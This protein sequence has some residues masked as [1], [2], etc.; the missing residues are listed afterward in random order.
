MKAFTDIFLRRPVLA[1]VVNLIIL[2]AGLQAIRSLNVRQYP[3]NENAS[4]TITTAYIGASAELVRGFITTP[5]ERAIAAADGIDYIESKSTMG[6]STITVRLKLNYDANKALAQISSKIDQVRND[7]PPEAEV[8]IIN[9][10]SADSQFAA[11][12][13]SFTSDILEANQITDYLVRVVQPRLAAIEGVQRADILGGRTFA[14]RIWL[15]PDRMAALNINPNQVRQALAANNFL[16]A[17]GRTKGALVQVNLTANTDLR[18]PEEFR[19]LVIRQEGNELVRLKDVADVVLGAE[20]YD[21]EVRFSGQQA[22]FMGIWVLPNAN[23]LDVIKRVREEMAAIQ[24]DLPTGMTASIAYDATRYIEDAISEVLE[25]LSETLLIVAIVIF[26]FLG[27]IRSVLVPLVAIPLSLIGAVFLM[28]VFGFTLNL[29]TLLAIVLSVGLVVDDAIVIVE[30][31]ERH[32]REGQ[33]PRRAALLGAREL[34]GP[35]IAMTI[36]LAAVYAPIGFQGGL[37][38]SLFREF[39]FTLAGAVFISGIVALTLSP[40]M[41]SKLLNAKREHTGLTGRINRDFERLKRLYAK[42]LDTTLSARPAVY[43]VWIGLSLLAFPMYMLAPKE[44]APTEDQGFLLGIVEAPADATIDQTTFYTE[45][46]NRELMA[47]PEWERTFQIT[48]PD[49]GFGG[50]VLKPWGERERTV[51]EIM[52]QVQSNLNHIPGVRTMV[53][54]PAALPG[55]GQFP[56]EVVIAST[57]DPETILGFAQQL[58]QKAATNGMFAFPPIID[59]K[60]DQPQVE[61]VLDRDKVASMGL[62]MATVGADLAA[63]V[64]GNF[65]NRFNL[66]GR[67]YK[68]IP[69]VQRADRLNPAQL[70]STYVKGPNNELVPVSTFAHLE[71]KTVPRS[72]NRF[73]QL[74]AVKISGVAIRPLDEAL[75]FFETEAAEILPRGYVLDYTGES[76]QLRVEGSKFLPAFVLAL[77]LIFLVLAAQ[78]N[79]FRDP[80]IILLGSV[81]LAMFGALIF[82]FLKMPGQN[83]PFWTEGWTTTLNIYSQ[84]GLV[85]LVGLVS[86]NGI[87]IVEFANELQRRG[88]SKIQAV[89]EAALVRL[90]P[91]L[92]TSAATICGHFPLTLVSGAGAAARNSIGIT[93]VAGMALG[94]LFTLLVIPAIYVLIAK[95]H[96]GEDPGAIARDFAPAEPEPEPEPAH[97]R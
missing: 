11:S 8:P 40:L 75:R 32:I 10:E 77:L 2:I 97:A 33:S 62:D 49:N 63:L 3:R 95:Q 20:D 43:A 94:T 87:L 58:Q 82:S 14:M 92:M 25:T 22:V 90:R 84:V 44:L 1:I 64:G 19:N 89:R 35:V 60:I 55:G 47:V 67:S 34:V 72:L 42:I 30:N 15:K 83:M 18:T 5:L 73:Q 41:S 28:Q 53:A 37:T 66:D 61:L 74:N 81:P 76:R 27:S 46:V 54:A 57:A 38:G 85:T 69:Q 45:A 93:I 79:S 13:L 16:S 9:I 68:V 80:F 26:L 51:F 21:S 70:G 4:I 91:V 65:V 17:V 56:V 86:K 71:R 31:V 78:F 29:L 39:A 96:Q 12:Y 7:L 23:T 36:T 88:L 6:L 52:P 59:T 48:F 24:K 50:L